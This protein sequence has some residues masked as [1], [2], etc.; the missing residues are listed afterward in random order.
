MLALAV[1]TAHG[2]LPFG[3][4]VHLP[5]LFA[6]EMCAMDTALG[7]VMCKLCGWA[8]VDPQRRIIYN[9]T[10][11]ACSVAIALVVGTLQWMRVVSGASE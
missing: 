1:G 7:A 3:A 5:I 8:C 2:A 11:T 9:I 6:A 4:V 10:L